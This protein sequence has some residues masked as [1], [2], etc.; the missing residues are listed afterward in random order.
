MKKLVTVVVIALALVAK[1]WGAGGVEGS[2]HDFSKTWTNSYGTVYGGWT[3]YGGVCS[4]CHAAHDTDDAQLVPLWNHVTTT[5]SFTPYSASS[6]QGSKLQATVGNPAGISLACLS[7]HDGTVAINQLLTGLATN[8]TVTGPLYVDS[9]AKKGPDLHTTHPIS[10]TYDAALATAD[11]QIENPTTY[12]IG[13]AKTKLT[14]QTAP[15]PASWSGT[16]LTGQTI[17]QALLWQHK[18]ECASC[19]DPHVL[20]GSAPTS[21]IFLRISGK[22]SDGRGSTVCRTCHVK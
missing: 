4:P 14:D 20:A 18:V 10:F 15:V 11:G 16:S 17:D 12:K 7:C 13:D 22:D 2:A 6:G 1:S 9:H 5:A 8:S 21:G 3:P 19:H